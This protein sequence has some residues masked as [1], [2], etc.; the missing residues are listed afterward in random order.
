MTVTKLLEQ[1][2]DTAAVHGVKQDTASKLQVRVPR[3]G[4]DAESC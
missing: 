3:A 2:R 1:G 4:Q